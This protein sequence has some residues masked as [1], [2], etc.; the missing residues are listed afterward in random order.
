MLGQLSGRGVC[1][2]VSPLPSLSSGVCVSGLIGRC[3][4]ICRSTSIF[5]YGCLSE[6]QRQ[7]QLRSQ[8]R[9]GGSGHLM[10]ADGVME[11]ERGGETPNQDTTCLKPVLERLISLC[12][13][14]GSV[15]PLQTGQERKNKR[16]R[17]ESLNF[18]LT[19]L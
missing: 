1:V 8:R 18:S 5:T 12:I 2:C 6:S 13:T 16:Q 4:C 11:G 10:P 19:D 7:T 17:G 15:R 9:S 14:F 3:S